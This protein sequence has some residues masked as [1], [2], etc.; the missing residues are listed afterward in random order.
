MLKEPQ[1][2]KATEAEIIAQLVESVPNMHM[3]LDLSQHM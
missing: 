1:G 3:A 2:L